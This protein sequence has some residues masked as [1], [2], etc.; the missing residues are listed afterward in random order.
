VGVDLQLVQFE[1]VP[2]EPFLVA[3]RHVQ[4]VYDPRKWEVS[5][6]HEYYDGPHCFYQFGPFGYSQ[7]W[8]WCKKC[9]PD[10]E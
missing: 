4:L 9:R 2:E 10:Q 1:G 3:Q 6:V 8:G 5:Q 7:S